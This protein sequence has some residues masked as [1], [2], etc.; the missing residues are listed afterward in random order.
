MKLLDK[1]LDN[2]RFDKKYVT[3]A[4]VITILGLIAGSLF[5]VV[6]NGADKTLVTEYI[7]E[8]IGTINDK[9]NYAN[10]FYNNIINNIS[11]VVLFT[12]IGLTYFLFPINILIL[13]YKAFVIGFSLASFI[14]TYK[15]KG[16]LI[17]LVYIFPHLIIDILIL[18][19]LTAFIVKLSLIMIKHIIKGT[20]INLKA[21]LKK[22]IYVLIFCILVIIITT[23]YESFVAPFIL[24]KIIKFLI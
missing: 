23:L 5:I 22:F 6:L 8:Y 9:F 7:S 2:V 4:I 24:Q 17:S 21:Y 11:T 15:I 18:C 16:L 14:L 3:F 13:F 20:N 19:L 1:L 10:Y 12:I